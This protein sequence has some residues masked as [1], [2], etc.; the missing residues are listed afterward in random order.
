MIFLDWKC[1]NSGWTLRASSK[2][3]LGV[4]A[5]LYW[6]LGAESVKSSRVASERTHALNVSGVNTISCRSA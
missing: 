6:A 5:M 1:L 3:T 4:A 2:V